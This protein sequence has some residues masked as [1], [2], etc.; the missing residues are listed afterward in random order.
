MLGYF[1]ELCVIGGSEGASCGLSW[2]FLGQGRVALVYFLQPLP[3]FCVFAWRIYLICC[4]MAAEFFELDAFLVI[5]LEGVE[6][7]PVSWK[8]L[9]ALV[10]SPLGES[11]QRKDSSLTLFIAH[12][13]L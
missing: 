4:S 7:L 3:F 5:D 6:S 11:I 10:V 13:N 1:V 12:Y 9:N 2:G 8:G